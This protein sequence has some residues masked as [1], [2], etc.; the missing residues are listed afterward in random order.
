MPSVALLPH[1]ATPC[2]FVSSIDI[3]VERQGDQLALRFAVT[4]Q[5]AR[6]RIPAEGPP[7][8]AD[9]LWRHTCF[10]AFVKSADCEQYLEFNFDPARRWASY[11]FDR[12]REGMAISDA[13]PSELTS[14]MRDDRLTL[15]VVVPLTPLPLAASN[16]LRLG[17]SAVIETH[18]GE[19]SYWALAHAP[20]KP[21]FHHVDNFLMEI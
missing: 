13:A 3:D 16:R 20:G 17:L 5:L 7:L 21:D 6:L 15:N 19:L 1:P 2:E 9:N 18:A 4:A 11:R 14:T 10:E 12:Y 8:R